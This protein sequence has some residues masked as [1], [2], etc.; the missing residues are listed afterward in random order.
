MSI[1]HTR[2]SGTVKSFV[3]R[4]GIKEPFESAIIS[5]YKYG[6]AAQQTSA[7]CVQYIKGKCDELT[8]F[9]LPGDLE[10]GV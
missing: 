5:C 7:L 6:E 9:W 8:Y 3:E 10:K 4:C 1:F 2:K